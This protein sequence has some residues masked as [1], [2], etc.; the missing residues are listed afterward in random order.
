MIE[1]NYLGNNQY[2]G[3][4]FKAVYSKRHELMEDIFLHIEKENSVLFKR[5]E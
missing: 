3:S 4:T 2:A 1:C 5:Y